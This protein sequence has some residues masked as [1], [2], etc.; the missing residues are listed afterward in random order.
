MMGFYKD[1]I[2]YV[3]EHAVDA[4]KRRYAIAEEAPRHFI[5][6]DHYG[7]YPFDFM[8]RRWKEAVEKYTEDTL[9]G[10]GILPWHTERVYYN[11]KKA[12]EERNTNAILRLSADIGQLHCRRTRAAAHHRK[13]QRPTNRSTRYPRLLGVAGAGIVWQRL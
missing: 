13:L 5:D 2:E 11:L 8:P 7:A 6:I 3:T 10:Y 12:F 1:H 4:D 9:Q